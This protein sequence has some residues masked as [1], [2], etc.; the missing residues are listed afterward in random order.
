MTVEN[1]SGQGV[2]STFNTWAAPLYQVSK[3]RTISTDYLRTLRAEM[4]H[5]VGRLDD[6]LKQREHEVSAHNGRG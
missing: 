4:L 5:V 1:D 6:E 2:N 3:L